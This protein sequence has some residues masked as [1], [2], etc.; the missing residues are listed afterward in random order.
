MACRSHALEGV[1]SSCGNI[2]GYLTT[3]DPTICL[4]KFL[5]RKIPGMAYTLPMAVSFAEVPLFFPVFTICSLS[6][7]QACIK[8]KAGELVRV[9][10]F[11]FFMTMTKLTFAMQNCVA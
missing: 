7:H 1:D 10:T 3:V 6:G 5:P 4:D 9:T 8:G 11:R 2:L